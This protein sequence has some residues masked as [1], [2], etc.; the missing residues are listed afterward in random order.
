[1]KRTVLAGIL[2]SAMTG[3]PGLVQ[4]DA[5]IQFRGT[6]IEAPPCVI[7]DG[8]MYTVDFGDVLMSGINTPDYT[9]N[10]EIKVQCAVEQNLRF[11]ISGTPGYGIWADTTF[12]TGVDGLGISIYMKGEAWPIAP[13]KWFELIPSMYSKGVVVMSASLV[14]LSTDL[15]GGAF[16]AG[17]TF[18]I[19]YP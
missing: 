18:A 12:D 5:D 11:R 14:A 17:T 15:A 8:E 19:D 9:R 2:A 16:R 4:A 13:N 6:L 10:F 3:L 1:M 7:N